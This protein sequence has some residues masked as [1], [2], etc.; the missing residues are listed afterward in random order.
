MLMQTRSISDRSLLLALGFLNG[1]TTGH[2]VD[3][4][5]LALFCG[6]SERTAQRWLIDG[7]PVRA[8]HHLESLFAG[9][10]LPPDWR[11]AGVKIAR[12]R[13]YLQSGH[14]MPLSAVIKWPFI[15]QAVDWSRVPT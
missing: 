6:V 7:L 10:Y 11:R 13:I 2:G 1:S 4:V 3:L 15:V 14:E 12:D 8:R 9:D 5:K